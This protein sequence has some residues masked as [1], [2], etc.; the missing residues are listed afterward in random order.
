MHTPSPEIIQLLTAFAPAWTQ[1][2]FARM[3]LLVCGAILAPGGR[4]VAAVLRVLGLG[5]TRHF[6]N[7]HRVLNRNRWSPFRLAHRLFALLVQLVPPGEALV[8][9]LDETLQRRQGAQLVYK[10]LFRDAVRSTAARLVCSWG[11][12]WCCLCLLVPVPWSTRRWALP[13]LVV[14]VRS[15]KTCRKFRRRHVGTVR[16]AQRLLRHVQAWCPERELVAVGDGA[17]AAVE[18]IHQCQTLTTRREAPLRLV[19]RLRWD[20]ALYAPPGQPPPGKRGPKPKKGVR[21]PSLATRLTD[22]ETPWERVDVAWYGGRQRTVEWVTGTAL[23]HTAGQDPVPLRWLLVREPQGAAGGLEP[24]ALCCSDPKAT[25]EQLLAWF[26]GRWNIEVTFAELR[27]H[28]GFET[29]RQWS[30][31]AVGRTTPCLCGLFSLVVLLAQRLYPAGLP[32]A[33]TG[34]YEKEAAT[35]SDVLAAVRGHLW[36]TGNYALSGPNLDCCLIP[37]PLL[38]ALQQVACYA[39]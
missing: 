38:A 16:W 19:S 1:P 11:V 34:W 17:Y 3:A 22:P 39:A 23:W 6:T 14:P 27:A 30:R 36:R 33:R 7:F 18:L 8:V 5:G 13:F 26:L 32:V 28:L 24:A 10:G 4:T 35:F 31:T 20:A 29:Q 25:P 12:R 15:E 37:R 21:L 9:L 2:T